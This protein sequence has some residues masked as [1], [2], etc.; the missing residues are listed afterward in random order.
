MEFLGGT[1]WGN[2]KWNFHGSIKIT[3]NFPGVVKNKLLGIFKVF[4]FR[5]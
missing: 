3:G 5:P 1:G 2:G 4:G